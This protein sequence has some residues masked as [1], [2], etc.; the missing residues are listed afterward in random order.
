MNLALTREA[1]YR[2]RAQ[3]VRLVAVQRDYADLVAKLVILVLFSSM[4]MRLRCLSLG[5]A[6]RRD[7]SRLW[8]SLIVSQPT[9]RWRATSRMV[10]LRESSNA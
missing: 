3:P 8:I 2:F 1:I 9:S 10:M 6:K 4:A 7:R 5:L